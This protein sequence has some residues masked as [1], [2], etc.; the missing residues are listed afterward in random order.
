MQATYSVKK[1]GFYFCRELVLA[2][3]KLVINMVS[4]VSQ[5]LDGEGHII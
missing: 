2:Q 5:I 3:N 4:Y 1:N